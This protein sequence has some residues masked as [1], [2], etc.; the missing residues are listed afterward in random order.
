MEHP[1]AFF[2]EGLGCTAVVFRLP[3][4]DVMGLFQIEA[5]WIVLRLNSQM[6]PQAGGALDLVCRARVH[7]N[8]LRCTKK[9]VGIPK[10]WQF[11]GPVFA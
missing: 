7:S 2:D 4:A 11:A 6:E 9:T 3:A 5:V 10:F 1:F 8:R